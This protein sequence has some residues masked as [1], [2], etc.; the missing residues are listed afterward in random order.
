MAQTMT[1]QAARSHIA[2]NKVEPM[3][4]DRIPAT[5]HTVFD[6][7]EH[8]AFEPPKEF[9]TLRDLQLSED[10]AISPVAVTAP[11]PLFS[12][13]GVKA[14]RANLFR[15]EVVDKHAYSLTPGCC[16]YRPEYNLLCV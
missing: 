9:I 5:T 16:T 12:T 7:T 11:F 14:L 1:L 15:R 13:E 4:S 6:P 3:S 8:L 10:K 2:F